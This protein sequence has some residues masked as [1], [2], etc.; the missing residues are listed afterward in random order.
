M[1]PSFGQAFLA[2]QQHIIMKL[3]GSKC[4]RRVCNMLMSSNGQTS[5]PMNYAGPYVK[6]RIGR[7]QEWT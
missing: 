3:L 7:H 2:T 4:K 1:S 5:H 6:Q